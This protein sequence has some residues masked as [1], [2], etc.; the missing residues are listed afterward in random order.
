MEIITE[1]YSIKYDVATAT[2]TW[3][4][5]MR[6]NGKEYAPLTTLLN[7]VMAQ[8]PTQIT[9]NLQGLKALNSSGITMLGRFVFG[10]QKKKTIQLLMQGS[11][12]IAWQKK[13]VK[14]FQRL[15]PKLQFEW[16]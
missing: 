16:A 14:N 11:K 13:S 3:Q 6:L 5:I 9:F 2:I 7:D 1:E 15:M 8:E 4:G 10:L 12:D